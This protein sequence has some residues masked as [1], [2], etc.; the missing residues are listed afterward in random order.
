[1]TSLQN[2][3]ISNFQSIGSLFIVRLD[4]SIF[5]YKKIMLMKFVVCVDQVAHAMKISRPPY[6]GLSV[7]SELY[8]FNP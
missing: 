6:W 4:V 8:S 3:L 5:F 1:M 2:K 7:Y